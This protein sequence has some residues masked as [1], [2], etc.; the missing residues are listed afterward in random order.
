MI[1]DH[2]LTNLGSFHADLWVCLHAD[3]I[4]A[5]LLLDQATRQAANHSRRRSGSRARR[6]PRHAGHPG[7]RSASSSGRAHLE[8]LTCRVLE[9]LLQRALS[10]LRLSGGISISGSSP[11]VH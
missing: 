11:W 7:L 8:A 6:T 9:S 4:H 10:L 1:P 3:A 5:Q 2:D